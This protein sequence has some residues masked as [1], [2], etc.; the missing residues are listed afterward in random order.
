MR[1]ITTLLARC[2][3]G[4]AL[5]TIAVASSPAP[6][7]IT[8]IA[9]SNP[10]TSTTAVG[11]R[12]TAFP[13]VA[14]ALLGITSAGIA[15][16]AVTTWSAHPAFAAASA[17]DT[18][19]LPAEG[20][21]GAF[22]A[23]LEDG[24]A[25][26]RTRRELEARAAR[27]ESL[28]RVWVYF[29]DKGVMSSEDLRISLE[30][31]AARLDPREADRRVRRGAPL[32]FHDL[33]VPPEY[34][35][36]LEAAG[37]RVHR[38][39]RWLNAASVELPLSRFDAVA[40]HPVVARL[41]PVRGAGSARGWFSSAPPGA[42]GAPRAEVR[43]ADPFDYGP[44]R[45]QLEQIAVI[46]AHVQGLSGAG[47]IVAIFD[48]GFY[49]DHPTFQAA[50]NQGRLLAQY[51]FVKN[52]GETQNE[53]GDPDSQHHH[54]TYTWSA[55]GGFTP[56]ELI[57][58]AHGA[59]FILAKTEDI[60]SETPIEEDNWIAAAEWASGLGAEVISTSL[61]Y[62]DW[63]TY[64]NMDGDT[65]PITIAADLGPSRG[66][67]TVVSAGNLGSAEWHYITAPA[68]GDSVL[69]VGAVDLQNEVASWSS[70]GPSF[71]GRIKPEVVALGVDTYCA[72]PPSFGED[73][74]WVS[75]TSLACPLV[76]GAA[77]LLCEAHPNWTPM[78]IRG[79]LLASADQSQTPDNDRGHGLIDLAAALAVPAAT[80]EPAAPSTAVPGVRVFPNPSAGEF[81]F[82]WSRPVPAGT[83]LS[84][85]VFDASGR[86]I[87]EREV[88]AGSSVTWDGSD[89]NGDPAP[90]G[91]YLAR[92][93]VGEWVAT[94]RVV[95]TAG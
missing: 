26:E 19:L 95:R 88:S 33:P 63:Y 94:V 62:S 20:A 79:A 32:D 10:S 52:D 78:M 39:S 80:P 44:S 38:V 60:E 50:I 6:G 73:Y 18:R 74:F 29:R 21:L 54:G 8:A 37:A 67:L 5:R 41:T 70:R 30:R 55:L 12:T 85:R 16:S 42:T 91:V 81:T 59:T 14:A 89:A 61:S 76:G 82:S 92:L 93:T 3:L 25:T 75:G 71:D 17:V 40:N 23:R 83:A 9:A 56:G 77:A 11:R 51:D 15:W 43:G 49:R 1:R 48:T 58:P 36:Q 28:P 72:I 86:E 24:V 45:P 34:L 47:V 27:G 57:G 31:A 64:E 87:G 65:A 4:P 35:S 22:G 84:L 13:R 7:L 66:F 2:A 68:D 46:P 90:A 69:S 53:P